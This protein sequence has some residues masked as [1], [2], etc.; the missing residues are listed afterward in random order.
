MTWLSEAPDADRRADGPQ[1]EIEA[2]RTLREIGNHQ[3]RNHAE[4][5]GSNPIQNLNCYQHNR[6]S[7]R[8]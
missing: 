6:L 3:D 7:V 5:A 8:V 2:S 4:D 1:R